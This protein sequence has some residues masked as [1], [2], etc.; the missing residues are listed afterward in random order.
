MSSFRVSRKLVF[1]KTGFI[2]LEVFGK[3]EVLYLVYSVK[4]CVSILLRL[5][6][7]AA[8]RLRLYLY[9]AIQ[10]GR[11]CSTFQKECKDDWYN[12]GLAVVNS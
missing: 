1:Q 11:Q 3:V 2:R 10:S 7:L 8:V 12:K 5:V 6:L 9:F 4:K